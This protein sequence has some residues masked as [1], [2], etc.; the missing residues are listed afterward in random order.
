MYYFMCMLAYLCLSGMVLLYGLSV[1]MFGVKFD[2]FYCFLEIPFFNIF[3]LGNIPLFSYILVQ[4]PCH[5]FS[6]LSWV[7]F[8]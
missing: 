5:I 8:D 2:F 1:I 6:A 3:K 4:V 7:L